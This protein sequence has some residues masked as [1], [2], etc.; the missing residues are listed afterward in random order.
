MSVEENKVAYQSY[1]D[2]GVCVFVSD[3]LSVYVWVYIFW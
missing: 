2:L 1:C 3:V